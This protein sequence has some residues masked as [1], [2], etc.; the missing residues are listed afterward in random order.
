MTTKLGGISVKE[1][2][3]GRTFFIF[4]F[5]L[6]VPTPGPNDLRYPLE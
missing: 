2:Q 6:T 4:K 5:P 1:N 3:G